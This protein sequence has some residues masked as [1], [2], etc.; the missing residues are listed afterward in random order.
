MED[1]A[2]DGGEVLGEGAVGRVCSEARGRAAGPRG[3]PGRLRRPS[4]PAA[5]MRKC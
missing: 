2:L 1:K 4:A 3:A 5:G